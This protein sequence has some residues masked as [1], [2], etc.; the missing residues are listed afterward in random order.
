[1]SETAEHV[2]RAILDA[3]A[4]EK[5]DLTATENAYVVCK[6]KPGGWVLWGRRDLEAALREGVNL[7]SQGNIDVYI[8]DSQQLRFSLIAVL[9]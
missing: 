4:N 2:G 8:L 3:A 7:V 1:M 9:R 5:M 6:K